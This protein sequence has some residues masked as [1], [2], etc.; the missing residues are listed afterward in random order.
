MKHSKA[1]LFLMELILVLL[2]FS[3]ASCICVRL[4]AKSGIISAQTKE[5]THATGLAQNTA[6]AFYG[7]TGDITAIA[8]LFP[9]STVSE[10]GLA[11]SIPGDSQRCILTLSHS[12]DSFLWG[13]ICVYSSEDEG[14]SIYQLSVKQYL[15]RG[16]ASHGN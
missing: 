7:F 6:E 10:D 8:E 13:D 14:N 3:I 9:G 4:F 12:E 11:L 2:F 5:L 15:P 16:G 1:S